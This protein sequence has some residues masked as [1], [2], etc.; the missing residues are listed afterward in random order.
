[1]AIG[2]EGHG[3]GEGGGGWRGRW[4]LCMT[5]GWLLALGLC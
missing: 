1:M 3:T 2:E 4:E 5:W